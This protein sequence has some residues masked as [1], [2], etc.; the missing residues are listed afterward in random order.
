MAEPIDSY[1]YQDYYQRPLSPQ[2][3]QYQRSFNDY[4]PNVGPTT[5]Q[6][7]DEFESSRDVGQNPQTPQ[8]PTYDDSNTDY[9]QPS[10]PIYDYNTSRQSL[11]NNYT[12]RISFQD[13]YRQTGRDRSSKRNVSSIKKFF[14]L[15]H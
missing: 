10:S 5:I 6:E 9:C 1:D 11:N 8:P 7:V 2:S 4:D 3:P 13:Q 12:I 14:F 15:F